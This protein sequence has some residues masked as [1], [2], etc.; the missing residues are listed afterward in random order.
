MLNHFTQGFFESLFKHHHPD[1]V[2]KVIKHHCA[3]NDVNPKDIF[4]TQQLLAAL[5]DAELRSESEA[6]NLDSDDN[7]PY[8]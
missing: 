5:T 7:D 1:A 3:E 4:T 8:C 2:C 6:R